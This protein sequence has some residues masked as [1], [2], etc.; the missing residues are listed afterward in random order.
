[1]GVDFGGSRAFVA[2]EFLY[3]AQ[4]GAVFQQVGGEGVTEGVETELLGDFGS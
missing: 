3:V 4:I 2:E 1:V